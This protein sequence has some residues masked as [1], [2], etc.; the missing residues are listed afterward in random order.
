MFAANT[1][2]KALEL[3]VDSPKYSSRRFADVPYLDIS[4]SY[5]NGSLV[6]NVVNRHRDQSIDAEFEAQDKQF[7][8]GVDV[9]E[10]SGPDIKSEND[11]GKVTVAP[12]TRRAAAQG[13]RLRYSFPAHSYTML[14]ARL[15]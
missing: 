1:K 2:G 12:V 5:D 4:A 9:T 8:G 11:F 15:A 6:I 7:S 13:N 3:F 14:K 10:V